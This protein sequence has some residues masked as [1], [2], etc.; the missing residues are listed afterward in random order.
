M[1]AVGFSPRSGGIE[2]SVAERRLKYAHP[3]MRRSGTRSLFHILRGLEVHGYHH[4]VA[5]RLCFSPHALRTARF[6]PHSGRSAMPTRAPSRASISTVAWPIPD[7]P[8]VTSAI[9]LFN[10]RSME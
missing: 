2:K 4:V 6:T 9:L 10:S 3:F 8:P 1:V 7:A 5:P